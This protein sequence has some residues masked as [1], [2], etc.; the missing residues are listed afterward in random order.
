MSDPTPLTAVEHCVR[1]ALPPAAAF[2][3][4]TRQIARWWPFVGHSCYGAEAADI[5]F[6]PRVG[7]AVTALARDGDR[8]GWE[9]RGD[10]AATR[11]NQYNAGWPITLVAFVASA[12]KEAMA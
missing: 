10:Q 7:G 11:R 2:E 5:E 6:E 1:V 4:F 12:G 9:A 3:L 8:I